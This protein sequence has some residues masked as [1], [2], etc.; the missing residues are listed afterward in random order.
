[1]L[2][3]KATARTSLVLSCV[4]S[5]SV[6]FCCTSAA[7]AQAVYQSFPCKFKTA[8]QLHEILVDILPDDAGR[9]HVVSDEQNNQVLVKG[10]PATLAMAAKILRNVD[11]PAIN[12]AATNRPNDAGAFRDRTVQSETGQ[13]Q[14]ASIRRQDVPTDN[15]T[16]VPRGANTADATTVFLPVRIDTDEMQGRLLKVL[17][18]RVVQLGGAQDAYAVQLNSGGTFEFEFDDRRKGLLLTGPRRIVPQVQRLL[19]ALQSH[20][21]T[22]ERTAVVTIERSDHAKLQQAIDAFRGQNR[23]SNSEPSS[24]AGAS[25]HKDSALS[26]VNYIFQDNASNE[27][28]AN[29]NAAPAIVGGSGGLD[30]SVEVETLPDLD[31]IILQGND[32]DVRKLTQI[33]QELERLSRETQPEVRIVEL[34]HAQSESVAEIVETVREDLTGRRQ[35]RVALTPLVKPN[36]ILLIGWGDAIDST[37]DLIQKLDTPV[38]PDT[39]FEVFRLSHATATIIQTAIT[40]FFGQRQGLGPQIQSFADARSNTVV[41][42][43][44]PRDMAEV[45]RLVESL[46]VSESK[47]VNR[48]RVFELRNALATDLAQTLTQAI[49]ASTGTAA[50]SD[51]LELLT[52]DSAGRKMIQSGVLADVKITANGRNNTLIVSGPNGSLPLVEALIRQLDS[53]GAV[54]QIK[55][56]RVV[57]GDAASMVQVLRSLLPA[58]SNSAGPSLPSAEGESSTA[59]LRF[60]VDN[61]TNSIIATGSEGDLEIIQTLI[62]RLDEKGATERVNEIYRLRNSPATDVAIA[63]NE[64]LRSER[65][66]SLA[67]AGGGG[68]FEQIE[69]EVVVVPEP[70]G[71]SLIISA[72]PRYFEEIKNLVEELDAQPPQV[73]IQVLIA[74]IQLNDSHE[75]GVELGIQDSVLFDRSLLG[76]LITTVN[77]T[78]TSTAA[79][80]VSTT[81]EVVQAATNL[82]GF[83]FNNQPLG[84]SGSTQALT[85]SDR[86]G[87]QGLSHFAVGRMNNELGFGGLVLSASSESVSVLI[88]ALQEA[89]RLDVLSRPQVRTLDNQPAFIQ[90]GQR[91]PRIVATNITQG[92][93]QTNSVELENVGLILGV[94]PRISPDGTVVMEIDAEKSSLGLEQEGIPITVSVDG[95]VI[96]SPRINTTTAQTTVSA[97]SGETIIIGG[98]ITKESQAVTRRVPYLSDIPLLGNAF[99]FDSTINKRNEL[100]IILTPHIIRGPADSQRIN[101]AEMAKLS[102]CEADVFEMHG[103]LGLSVPPEILHDQATEVIYPA[104]NP[105]GEPTEAPLPDSFLPVTSAATGRDAAVRSTPAPSPSDSIAPPTNHRD[106]SVRSASAEEPVDAESGWPFR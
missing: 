94:T 31:V 59:P 30:V 16:P 93:L 13:P 96:R 105:S 87:S 75:F 69:R 106:P 8:K 17:A 49:S 56:F 55:V 44:A 62:L 67:A 76:D 79:G 36:A 89:R 58:N 78:Q 85:N 90:V 60:S 14:Q 65:I 66:V 40:Q 48:A 83:N 38:S 99:R 86:V 18:G 53:P 102:W 5:M 54:A 21:T 52:V 20:A 51:V 84:N 4:V 25:L 68:A 42:Y 2:R 34:S 11:K 74:E 22:S 81:Q 23:N 82:P 73:M 35:G 12:S 101:Q 61:R 100:L 80:V 43:A 33:I 15:R 32:R 29:P 92:G 64:F 3:T 98:L 91:V 77:S 57:N 47:I 63:V 24:D 70:V 45:K 39:Q 46:D 28:D 19:S 1:M 37:V 10:S 50:G 9:T 26:L 27:S 7:V 71:N 88:R 104:L 95:S 6:V 72:T 41:V 97:A 103:D